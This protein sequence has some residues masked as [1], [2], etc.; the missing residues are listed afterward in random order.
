[1]KKVVLATV[2]LFVGFSLSGCDKG[3]PKCDDNDGKKLIMSILADNGLV[4]KLASTIYYKE[5]EPN[6][7]DLKNINNEISASWDKRDKLIHEN[8]YY[9]NNHL[10]DSNLSKMTLIYQKKID[11]MGN[12]AEQLEAQRSSLEENLHKEAEIRAKEEIE[13]MKLVNIR[14]NNINEDIKLCGCS[15]SIENNDGKTLIKNINYTLQYT[16]EGEL[17]GRV[18]GL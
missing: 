15:A 5:L 3:T 18:F 1:M 6:S 16:S 9:T 7:Q 14:T 12:K 13:K 17:Y 4:K 8:M 10:M 2:V 11:E